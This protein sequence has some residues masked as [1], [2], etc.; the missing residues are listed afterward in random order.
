MTNPLLYFQIP[1][2]IGT[3]ASVRVGNELGAGNPQKAKRAAFA[4][5]VVQGMAIIK[6]ACRVAIRIIQINNNDN[7]NNNY[8]CH[9]SGVVNY[10][11]W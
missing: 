2:G 6:V 9:C 3:A 1:L 5:L 4:A 11:C 8:R 7:N 10:L